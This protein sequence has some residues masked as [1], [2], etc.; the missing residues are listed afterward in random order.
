[1]LKS[2]SLNRCHHSARESAGATLFC[3]KDGDGG[4]FEAQPPNVAAS[5][6]A[7]GQVRRMMPDLATYLSKPHQELLRSQQRSSSLP[8]EFAAFDHGKLHRA[9]GV[10]AKCHLLPQ[11]QTFEWSSHNAYVGARFVHAD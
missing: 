7:I 2:G 3:A 8:S 5:A 1:M 6:M 11:T 10:L 9:I 4:A